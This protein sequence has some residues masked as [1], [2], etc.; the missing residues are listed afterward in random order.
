MH[1]GRRLLT[2]VVLVVAGSTAPAASA[3]VFE[4]H[5]TA[6]GAHGF[7][8]ELRNGAVR[9]FD[10]QPVFLDSGSV[11]VSRTGEGQTL[12]RTLTGHKRLEVTATKRLR[13][14][15]VRLGFGRRGTIDLRFRPTGRMRDVGPDNCSEHELHGRRG[16]FRGTFRVKM[17]GVVGTLNRVRLRGTL[18]SEPG[19]VGDCSDSLPIGGDEHLAVADGGISAIFYRSVGVVGIVGGAPRYGH[20]WSE[21]DEIDVHRDDLF[22]ADLSTFPINATAAAHAQ[23]GGPFLTGSLDFGPVSG[24]TLDGPS[25]FPPST[26]FAVPGPVTGSMTARFD[27]LG[28]T[29][30]T[31]RPTDGI[32]ARECEQCI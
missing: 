9:D 21:H 6:R 11:V 26:S 29:A 32:L 22:S 10:D 7:A 5:A 4:V 13:R 30:T 27:R 18:A 8:V 28:G 20:R 14:G 25:T 17:G 16:V 23:A 19:D 12:S 3:R 1:R 24:F 2:L 31:M 15:R